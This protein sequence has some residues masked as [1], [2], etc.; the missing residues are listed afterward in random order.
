MARLPRTQVAPAPPAGPALKPADAQ[1]RRVAAAVASAFFHAQ[2]D[3]AAAARAVGD[4]ARARLY[5]ADAGEF[6]PMVD[7]VRGKAKAGG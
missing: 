1:L 2:P 3:K 7:E 4:E 6:G 5:E